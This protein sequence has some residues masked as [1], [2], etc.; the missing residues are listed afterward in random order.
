M[1]LKNHWQQIL[2]SSPDGITIT[3]TAG[4]VIFVSDKIIK[5]IGAKS[6]EGILGTDLMDWIHPDDREKAAFSIKNAAEG[7][8]TS[9]AEEYR[10]IRVDKTCLYL[11][12]KG[13]VFKD[14]NNNTLGMIYS[15][16]DITERKK[17]EINQLQQSKHESIEA[18][19]GGIAHDFNNILTVIKGQLSLIKTDLSINDDFKLCIIETESAIDQAK[20]ITD[21]LLSL[22]KGGMPIKST[23]SINKMVEE[24]VHIV[25]QDSNIKCNFRYP[26]TCFYVHA[27]QGQ[28]NRV[29]T[30]LLLNAVESMPKGGDISIN[31]GLVNGFKHKFLNEKNEYL[32]LSVTD[33][34]NGISDENLQ[35]IFDP[36]FS[37]KSR[38]TGLGLF[39][40]FSIMKI[41]KGHL[42]AAANSDKGSVFTLYLPM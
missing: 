15:S 14:D 7:I 2:T 17:L 25:I 29:L 20:R 39:S 40:S 11:E 34:G 33:T 37:T 4:K 12:S 1:N 38:G 6:D 13:R 24:I 31:M 36:H 28:I 23:F 19:A 30:N 5:L 3:D 9:G 16:R 32:F 41:H 10:M 22:A 42:I 8:P 26:D 18:L 27:D 35:R 21:Q